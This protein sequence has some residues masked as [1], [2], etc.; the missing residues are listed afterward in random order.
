MYFQGVLP[1][2]TCT[3]GGVRQKMPIPLWDVV[4]FWWVLS[5]NRALLGGCLLKLCTS[6]GFKTVPFSKP[7]TFGWLPLKISLKSCT[8]R[9]LKTVP[10][11]VLATENRAL[12][13]VSSL[14]FEV[15]YSCWLDSAEAFILWTLSMAPLMRLVEG[16]P[17]AIGLAGGAS[18]PL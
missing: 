2:K 7:C 8:S 11:W 13:S 16:R 12:R 14:H 4:C 10:F 5:Q 18:R 3:F 15:I 17:G 9:G 1:P 6:R